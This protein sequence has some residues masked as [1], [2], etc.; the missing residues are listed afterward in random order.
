MRRESG[1]TLIEIM[2]VLAI[3]AVLMGG[4]AFIIKFAGE[5]GQRAETESLIREIEAS[6]SL[7]RGQDNLGEYPPTDTRELRIG[8]KKLGK[9]LGISNSTC[10]GIETVA[11]VLFMGELNLGSTRIDRKYLLNLDNDQIGVKQLTVHEN[12]D[13]FEIRDAWEQPLIYIHHRDYDRFE[14]E[15]YVSLD[16]QGNEIL[17]QPWRDETTGSWYKLESYQL[18]SIGPD[19]EPNT[20]DDIRN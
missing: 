4:V 11:L 16:F 8:S 18:F 19:G 7:V 15:P 1:F 14:S 6:L 3:M 5:A 13:L 2:V 10:M 12:Q 17:V 20:D 9:T